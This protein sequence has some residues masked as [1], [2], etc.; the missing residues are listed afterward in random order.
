MLA[1]GGYIFGGFNP[2]SWVS[3][4]MYSETDQSYLFSVA[5]PKDS[6]EDK[7]RVENMKMVNE[8]E[9]LNFQRDQLGKEVPV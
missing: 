4:F 6:S 2:E 8:L 7:I 5:R 9:R 1:N 3:E